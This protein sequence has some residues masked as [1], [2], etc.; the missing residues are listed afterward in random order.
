M[1]FSLVSC[2]LI[3]INNTYKQLEWPVLSVEAFLLDRSTVWNIRCLGTCWSPSVCLRAVKTNVFSVIAVYFGLAGRCVC[4]TRRS[5]RL[6]QRE[7]TQLWFEV[8][9]KD[10]TALYNS[11]WHRLTFASDCDVLIRRFIVLIREKLL[12]IKCQCKNPLVILTDIWCLN[13]S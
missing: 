9:W 12:S 7:A 11:P 4:E 10:N 8:C 5:L 6:F 2:S 1:Y 3:D 13:E